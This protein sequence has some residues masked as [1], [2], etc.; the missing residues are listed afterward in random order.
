MREEGKSFRQDQRDQPDNPSIVVRDFGELD[1]TEL[2]E[3]S[4]AASRLH[5]GRERHKSRLR[6]YLS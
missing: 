4:R 3:V 5:G 2:I 6:F 1:S